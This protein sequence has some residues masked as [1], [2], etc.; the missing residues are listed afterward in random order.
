MGRRFI[1][2]VWCVCL[3]LVCLPASAGAAFG[4]QGN[5]V[6]GVEVFGLGADRQGGVYVTVSGEDSVR[7]YG[8]SGLP[9]LGGTGTGDG[10]F[11]QPYDVAVVA[12]GDIFATDA[13]NTRIQRFDAAGV[14]EHQWAYGS[15]TGRPRH[16]TTDLNGNVLAGAA[17]SPS[18]RM[19]DREG[20]FIRRYGAGSSGD[21]D[22]ELDSPGGADVDAAGN[23][24]SAW[25]VG[26][27]GGSGWQV[28]TS[29]CAAGLRYDSTDPDGPDPGDPFDDPSDVSVNP[30]S[31]EVLVADDR[32][33]RRFSPAG[34]LRGSIG[35]I[36]EGASEYRR[37]TTVEADCR[38]RVYIGDTWNDKVLRF[39]DSEAEPYPCAA[40]DPT[41]PEPE[42]PGN[43]GPGQTGTGQTGTGDTAAPGDDAGST[44]LQTNTFAFTGG[45]KVS[46]NGVV[47]RMVITVPGP[48][49]VTT[50]QAGRRATAASSRRG[51]KGRKGERRSKALLGVTRKRVRRAGRVRVKARLS[52]V[53]KRRLRARG[54]VSVRVK[55]VYR[56]TR[57]K[58]VVRTKR[59]VFKK[60]H[61]G[62]CQLAE[63]FAQAGA[64]AS[65]EEQLTT[66]SL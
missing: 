56:P 14:F 31:G 4:H 30:V 10:Q 38:G 49:T 47:A 64:P 18:V 3:A 29:N 48:G 20:A 1:F 52:R 16:L 60:K 26:V 61:R 32:F 42:Q 44:A 46:P 37:P 65:R 62:K 45:Y 23:F 22:G 41:D 27:A 55:V 53:G 13:G 7:H 33:V 50:A 40:S 21:G 35:S 57:G 15:P 66:M 9:T 39:G 63:R 51:T 8:G 34:S 12:D 24:V 43:P 59:I 25:G 6:S 11:D 36:G 28:C 17:N 2:V 54:K 58:T 5:V 19:T